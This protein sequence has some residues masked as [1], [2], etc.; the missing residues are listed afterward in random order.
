MRILSC[1][2]ASSFSCRSGLRLVIT[3]LFL[4]MLAP[5]LYAQTD[6]GDRHENC[7]ANG[8]VNTCD[9]A[10]FLRT[11]GDTETVAIYSLPPDR[12]IIKQLTQMLKEMGKTI[13]PS[14]SEAELT[15][16]LQRIGRDNAI[17]VGPGGESLARL[18]IYGHGFGSGHE[19]MLWSETYYGPADMAW[20]AVVQSLI[21]QFQRSIDKK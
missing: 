9:K 11:L 14:T 4:A 7:T 19:R 17:E 20:P 3:A 6:L 5:A 2:A 10:V 13:E 1:S 8:R 18:T 16:V 12:V 15:F 21:Q